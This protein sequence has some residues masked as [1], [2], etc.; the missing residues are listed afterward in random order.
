[1]A[2]ALLDEL[3]NDLPTPGVGDSLGI[4]T[5]PVIKS[6]KPYG[7][8]WIRVWPPVAGNVPDFHRNFEVGDFKEE[9]SKLTRKA[10]YGVVDHHLRWVS[11]LVI[12]VLKRREFIREFHDSLFAGHM[13]VT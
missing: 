5:R 12:P 4:R 6:S 11:Q 9:I 7:H 8:G 1:M 10:G 13:G 2:S 3:T